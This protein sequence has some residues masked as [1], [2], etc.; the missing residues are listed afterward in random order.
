V[1]AQGAWSKT[2]MEGGWGSETLSLG[3]NPFKAIVEWGL[4]Q[5]GRDTPVRN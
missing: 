4:A 1:G 2:Q 5:H 3:D